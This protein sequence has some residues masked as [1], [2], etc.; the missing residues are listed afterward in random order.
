MN[1]ITIFQHFFSVF[2]VKNQEPHQKCPLH[3]SR[4]LY[5]IQEGNK[6]QE[7]AARWVC[8]FCGKAFYSEHYLDKHFENKH[9]DQLVKVRSN[10][11][12]V[13]CIGICS[14]PSTALYLK[15]VIKPFLG[16][17]QRVKVLQRSL[18][19]FI[20]ILRLR[21]SKAIIAKICN[22]ASFDCA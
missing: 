13:T 9:S 14:M 22:W 5:R 3:A 21:S 19:I 20:K 7:Y 15:D 10:C 11:F 16:E 1:I 17:N 8:N 18:R 6:T 2:Q 12:F 4:D